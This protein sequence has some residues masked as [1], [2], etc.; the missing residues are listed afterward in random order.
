MR[1]SRAPLRPANDLGF[2]LRVAVGHI[3]PCLSGARS[4]LRKQH[5]CHAGSIGEFRPEQAAGIPPGRGRLRWGWQR[6]PGLR[7]A[8]AIR[9]GRPVGQHR[10]VSI[11]SRWNKRAAS[12]H[13]LNSQDLCPGLH[14]SRPETGRAAVPSRRAWTWRPL[15]ELGITGPG[16]AAQPRPAA[17]RQVCAAVVPVNESAR[18]PGLIGFLHGSGEPCARTRPGP[19]PARGSTVRRCVRKD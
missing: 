3:E 4:G 7:L 9:H 6:P 2:D 15:H 18:E 1:I 19:G 16:S 17:T 8:E 11:I 5:P 13:G 10:D 14:R 12:P